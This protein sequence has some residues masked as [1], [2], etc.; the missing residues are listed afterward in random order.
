MLSLQ[1]LTIT[2]AHFLDTVRGLA[3]I[4]AFAWTEQN[5]QH[6][7]IL[8][9]NS[10]RP[11]YL[12]AMI[13]NWLSLTL[14]LMVAAIALVVISL[15]TQTRSNAG[16]TGASLVTLMT[17]G[18]TVTRL[19]RFYTQLE[20]SIGAVARIKSFSE[21][22]PPEDSE[23]ES[24]VPPESWPPSGNIKISD[25]SASYSPDT[26]DDHHLALRNLTLSISAGTKVAICGRSGRSVFI[27]IRSYSGASA[28]DLNVS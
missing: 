14:D 25:V 21:S 24:V 15:A 11:A 6:N 27:H 5:V 20:T 2:R 16:F 22:T 23:G 4:R 13:Q 18:Q 10:Q 12:L 17:L 3:T 7:H 26:D 1:Y 19:I 28:A 8:L 9:T